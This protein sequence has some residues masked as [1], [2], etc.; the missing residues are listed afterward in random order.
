MLDKE[1]QQ[2]VLFTKKV[3]GFKVKVSHKKSGVRSFCPGDLNYILY[4]FIYEPSS[5]YWTNKQLEWWAG[6]G[7]LDAWFRAI[8]FFFGCHCFF[9]PHHCGV[10]V[11]F[12]CIPPG[13]AFPA[14]SRR[15]SLLISYT[16]LTHIHTQLMSL[17]CGRRSS[18][19]LLKELLHGLSP[20]GARLFFALQA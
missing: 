12:G 20:L 15:V 17:F 6:S 19:S 3:F 16:H 7:H 11:F 4:A 13:S 10:L 9:S 14:A 8:G 18:Q 2:T 5:R 1:E